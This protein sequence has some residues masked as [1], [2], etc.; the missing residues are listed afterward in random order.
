MPLEHTMP[1]DLR[2][3]RKNAGYAAICAL[4]F[5]ADPG[6]FRICTAENV[7]ALLPQVQP[8]RWEPINFVRLIWTPG[9]PTAKTVVV[10]VEKFLTDLRMNLGQHWF[11]AGLDVFDDL[12][13]A[14][15]I[16]LRSPTWSNDELKLRLRTHA[17]AEADRFARGAF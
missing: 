10:G 17:N 11:R 6:V 9:P 7:E 1:L 14:E 13:K 3:R 2:R 15:T 4:G 12:V 8:G 5:D 16:K